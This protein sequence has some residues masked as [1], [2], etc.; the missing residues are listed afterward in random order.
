MMIAPNSLV[1]H[2]ER[3]QGEEE[4]A[5]DQRKGSQTGTRT[6]P[7]VHLGQGCQTVDQESQEC[8]MNISPRLLGAI[9]I[10][11]YLLPIAVYIY[12]N[13]RMEDSRKD[14]SQ[15]WDPNCVQ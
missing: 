4:E 6:L 1:R 14:R 7:H 10:S 5:G 8:L 15:L 11:W 2:K 3:A 13:I 12:R 9:S